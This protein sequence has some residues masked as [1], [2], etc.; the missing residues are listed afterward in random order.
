[1]IV[2]LTDTVVTGYKTTLMVKAVDF[3]NLEQEIESVLESL[4]KH[5][6]T[7]ASSGQLCPML[8]VVAFA[9][10]QEKLEARRFCPFYLEV[11]ILG[12]IGGSDGSRID[13]ILRPRRFD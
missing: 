4:S 2:G 9:A 7:R 1:M 6:A 13:I 8:R 11:D 5:P 12:I 3:T 10:F